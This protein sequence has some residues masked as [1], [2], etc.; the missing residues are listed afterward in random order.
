MGYCLHPTLEA[1]GSLNALKMALMKRIKPK[2]ILIHHS[3]RGTQYCSADYVAMLRSA[4]IEISMT[5]N[6]DPYENAVAE[7]VNGILKQDF[8]LAREFRSREE[9]LKVIDRSIKAYNEIRPHMSCNDLTPIE[10]H[11]QSG[12]L[13]KKWKPKSYT[14]IL[15]PVED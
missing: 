2:N 11:L 3:D 14:K 5:D 15:L 10:A 13:P 4:S 6:G 7:R 12:E 1:V 9:A 8:D